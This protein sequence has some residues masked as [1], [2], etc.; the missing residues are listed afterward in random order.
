M[1]HDIDWG[2]VMSAIAGG[3][4][5]AALARALITR[6]LT[7]LDTV[8]RKVEDMLV[9]LAA[10]NVKL[11]AVDRLRTT[12]S[13]H[14]RQIAVLDARSQLHGEFAAAGRSPSNRAP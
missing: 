13:E 2:T 9:R 8:T 7:D 6:A 3:G 4:A 1:P 5:A 11:E 14:D 10:I 12:V